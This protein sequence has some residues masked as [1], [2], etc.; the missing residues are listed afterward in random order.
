[1]VK[2]IINKIPTPL[3]YVFV[4]VCIVALTFII[5]IIGFNYKSIR[6][7]LKDTVYNNLTVKNDTIKI[8]LKKTTYINKIQVYGTSEENK[9]VHYN[10]DVT[11]VSSYGKENKKNYGDALYPELGT[12]YT[13]VGQYGKKIEL[14]IP[15]AY[16]GEIK[17]VKIKNSITLNKYRMCFVFSVLVMIAM[18]LFCKNMLRNRIELFFLII[19][20]LIGTSII[21]ST[22]STPFTWDEETHFKTVYENAYGEL[23][24]NTSAVIK[25]EEK[26]GIPTYNTLEEKMLVDNY[27]NKNDKKVVSRT[28][29]SVTINYTTM[30]YAPQII[31]AKIARGLNLSFTNMLRLMKFMNLLVYLIVITVAIR[32][33]KIGKYALMCIALMPTSILQASAITYDGFVLCLVSLG[34]VLLINE[35][36]SEEENINTKLLAIGIIAITI[37]SLSKMVYAP[38]VLLAIFIPNKKFASKKSVIWF[39]LGIL[40]I[41][42]WMLATFVLPTLIS[43]IS[44]SVT[45]TADLRGGDTNSGSQI[46]NIIA[47][48]MAYIKQLLISIFDFENFRNIGVP[49]DSFFTAGNLMLMNYGGTVVCPNKFAYVIMALIM[50]LIC[51]NKEEKS[52]NVKTKLG[53]WGLIFIIVV[54]I[55]TAMYLAFTPVGQTAIVG[56]QARYYLPILWLAIV[57]AYNGKL[58]IN[59]TKT[60][61]ARLLTGIMTFITAYG[62]LTVL[63]VQKLA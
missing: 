19:G 7:G 18:I 9:I 46:G 54:L 12:G 35:I 36:V 39:K 60:G 15:K 30:A 59:M 3:L 16:K 37:G 28:N 34:V 22:G 20:F 38:L 1:M 45:A 42:G 58:S 8:D 63:I 13:Y 31:G 47:N 53:V 26:I 61:Y 33:A 11:T 24:D 32:Y 27:M 6:Y 41:C 48:P 14:N 57:A 51:K 2:K 44:P 5:E 55:W 56:V 49:S 40:V 23:V 43:M 17:A 62:L 25:Y 52:L 4:F 29:K 50:L 21:Y 10:F